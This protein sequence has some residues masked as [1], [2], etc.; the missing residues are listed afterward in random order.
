VPHAD[1]VRDAARRL[2][3]PRA[4]VAVAGS[5][6]GTSGHA[7]SRGSDYRSNADDKEFSPGEPAPRS[8]LGRAEALGLADRHEARPVASGLDR[9]RTVAPGASGPGLAR[10]V[11]PRA[12]GLVRQR[13]GRSW[14]RT[15]RRHPA[16]QAGHRRWQQDLQSASRHSRRLPRSR[17]RGVR[18][19]RALLLA[20][21]EAVGLRRK[22]L[23]PTLPAALASH[24]R[25]W[26]VPS[27]VCD[28]CT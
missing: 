7:R 28:A 8:A 4:D 1:Y 3:A 6:F 19:L 14:V 13:A 25:P 2:P 20:G 11:P 23:Q 27:K 12:S 10:T 5:A 15:R 17:R 16:K 26:V 22:P 9:A 21:R 24:C 18:P